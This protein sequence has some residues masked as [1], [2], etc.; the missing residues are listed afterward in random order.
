[1]GATEQ[2]KRK[3][4]SRGQYS[5]AGAE[6]PNARESPLA[7]FALT[8]RDSD[9]FG[10]CLQQQ[11]K[12]QKRNEPESGGGGMRLI[13]QLHDTNVV[14][15]ISRCRRRSAAYARPDGDDAQIS[16]PVCP[17]IA[18]HVGTFHQLCIALK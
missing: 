14:E 9:F 2:K 18:G 1:M 16:S 11:T 12:K 15:K 5:G 10:V 8:M 4:K 13:K 17:Q 7:L 6:Q 3:K